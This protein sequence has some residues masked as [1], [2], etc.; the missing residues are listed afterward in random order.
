MYTYIYTVGRDVLMHAC[1]YR[2]GEAVQ[3]VQ[4][5]TRREH[6]YVYIYIYIYTKRN[7]SLEVKYF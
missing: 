6:I 5:R 1:Q 2:A 4:N 3:N 7:N